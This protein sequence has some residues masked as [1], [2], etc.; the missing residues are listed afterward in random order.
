MPA[1]DPLVFDCINCDDLPAKVLQVYD[2]IIY[3]LNYADMNDNPKIIFVASPE[4]IEQFPD[5]C[6]IELHKD[7]EMIDSA[8]LL[9]LSSQGQM[10]IAPPFGMSW[11]DYLLLV[12]C[13]KRK[14]LRIL[15]PWAQA[16]F[17]NIKEMIK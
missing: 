16:K 10:F 5:P 14:P 17:I 8:Y 6:S 4:T 15:V 13:G 12:A 11:D 1:L 3:K 7:P 2:Y 9:T